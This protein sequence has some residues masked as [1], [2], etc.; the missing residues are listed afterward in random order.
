MAIRCLE[1][2][3]TATSTRRTAEL[4]SFFDCKNTWIFNP[5]KALQTY[6]QMGLAGR[7][8]KQRIPADPRNLSW[9]DG[10]PFP[11]HHHDHDHAH[12]PPHSVDASR[13]GHSYLAKFGWD[14]SQGLGPSGDGMKTHL[15]VEQKL[16]MM[17][18][19]A[20]HQRDPNGI[21]WKQ[22][23]EFEALLKKLNESIEQKKGAGGE[24]AEEK[25]ER[26]RETTTVD[27]AFVRAQEGHE[28]VEGKM[29]NGSFVTTTKRKHKER[30]DPDTSAHIRKK[31]K[32]EKRQRSSSH[33]STASAIDST[34][35]PPSAP[36]PE[37][38]PKPRPMA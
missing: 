15:K 28:N 22:N 38:I 12:V 11:W 30:D 8:Q 29:G 32:K 1:D 26:E 16:D 9:A 31:Q 6:A 35:E 36:H 21:A 2:V 18:I 20:Q 27:K 5:Q 17:G 19:G 13:F 25:S 4:A 7:K 37:P 14:A 3:A 23:K 10:G 34:S 33:E 24:D